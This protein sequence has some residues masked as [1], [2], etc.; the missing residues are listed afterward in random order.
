MPAVKTAG[1]TDAGGKTAG[2]TG[3][4]GRT[5]CPAMMAPVH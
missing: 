4:A 2:A 3:W 1:T 5:A